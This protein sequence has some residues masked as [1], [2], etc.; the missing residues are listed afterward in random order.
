M[1]GAAWSKL[2]NG[3][4]WVAL[5][6]V[7]LGVIYH[8]WQRR[9][10]LGDDARGGLQGGSPSVVSTAAAAPVGAGSSREQ[11][12]ARASA[13]ATSLDALSTSEVRA[14]HLHPPPT[15]FAMRVP[16]SPPGGAGAQQL[17]LYGLFKQ[18]KLG[19]C[20]TPRPSLLDMRAR[21]KWDAWHSLGDTTRGTAMDLYTELVTTAAPGECVA[22]CARAGLCAGYGPGR[23]AHAAPSQCSARDIAPPTGALAEAAARKSR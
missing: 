23:G 13:Y 16:N 5:A 20:A 9:R 6:A 11:R 22:P 17:R 2:S 10:R 1:Q 8:R 12:F 21:A 7:A 18:A 19:R 14:R 3:Q 15:A 4:L